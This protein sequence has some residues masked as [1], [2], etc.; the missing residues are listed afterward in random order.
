M[1]KEGILALAVVAKNNN[2]TL[3]WSSSSSSPAL[4][5]QFQTIFYC[6]LD[7]VEEKKAR[8]VLISH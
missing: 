3:F 2:Q 6:S 4:D 5:L 7:I 1:A 8:L